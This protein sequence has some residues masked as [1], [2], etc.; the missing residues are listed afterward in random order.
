MFLNLYFGMPALV[1]SGDEIEEK[2][3][4]LR[5]KNENASIYLDVNQFY[6]A[7]LTDADLLAESY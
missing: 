5:F 2:E 3:R 7:K 1:V 4:M 6:L